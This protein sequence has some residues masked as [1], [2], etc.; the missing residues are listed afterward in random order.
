MPVNC[1]KRWAAKAN[2]KRVSGC[3]LRLVDALHALLQTAVVARLTRCPL[4]VKRNG[5]AAV[6]ELSV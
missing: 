2:R 1:E 3:T 6:E 4:R 5:S